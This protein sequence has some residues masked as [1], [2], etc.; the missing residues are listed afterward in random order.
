MKKLAL[1]SLV[2]LLLMPLS[3]VMAQGEKTT[4]QN[5]ALEIFIDTDGNTYYPGET[6]WIVVQNYGN[7]SVY[8]LEVSVYDPRSQKTDT[9]GGLFHL[10]QLTP[11]RRVLILT[12][13]NSYYTGETVSIAICNDGHRRESRIRVSVYG[14]FGADYYLDT[15]RLN[16][17]GCRYLRWVADVD[18]GRYVIKCERSGDEL[19]RKEIWVSSGY[20]DRW[21]EIYPGRD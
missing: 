11:T 6:V 12:D 14:R 3:G 10:T 9:I 7:R 17:G 5:P 19:A 2:L 4:R 21:E 8:G 13:K 15:I 16:S 1:A 20:Y 18:T